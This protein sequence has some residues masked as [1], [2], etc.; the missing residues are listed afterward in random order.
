[1][2]DAEQKPAF[3]LEDGSSYTGEVFEDD[4][5][6]PYGEQDIICNRCGGSGKW[7]RRLA[8][9][10]CAGEGAKHEQVRVYTETTLAKLNAGR[11]KRSETKVKKEME[12]QA[13]LNARYQEYRSHNLPLIEAAE[14]MHHKLADDLLLKARE[15][16][17]MTEKQQA[18]LEKLVRE[19][20]TASAL[21]GS[22]EAVGEPGERMDVDVVCTR[23]HSFQRKKFKGRG[24][25]TVNITEMVDRAG[26]SYLS[27]TANFKLIEG[28]RAVLKGTVKKH[29]DRNG[30]PQTILNRVKIL[31][32]NLVPFPIAG[33]EI[34][35]GSAAVVP[36]FDPADF[37]DAD[38]DVAVPGM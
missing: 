5:G 31:E 16:G 23:S 38:E 17:G 36:A 29:D 14:A 22:S 18:L 15:W 13:L 35:A 27:I 37:A 20:K 33:A 28:E 12:R 8:C 30:W 11:E 25:E 26:N 7:K 1:M 21:H 6:K 32:R 3:F 9:F 10:G 24:R 2:D 4:K 34:D 19:H